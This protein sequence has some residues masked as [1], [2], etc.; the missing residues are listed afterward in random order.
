MLALGKRVTEKCGVY[1]IHCWEQNSNLLS[2]GYGELH[3]AGQ[4]DQCW[5]GSWQSQEC[6]RNVVNLE[7]NKL[8][9]VEQT[10]TCDCV[11]FTKIFR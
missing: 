10:I 4:L 9:Y 7:R 6:F 5:L 11:N 3:I 8:Y 2:S 1:L